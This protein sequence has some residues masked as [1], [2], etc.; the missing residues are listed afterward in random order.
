MARH[1]RLEVL[2]VYCTLQGAE[3]GFDREFGI[4]VAWDVP[5]LDRYP[6]VLAPPKVVKP[7]LGSFWGLVNPGLWKL[8]R[9]GKFDA[10]FVFGHQYLSCW[11][12]ILATKLSRSALIMSCD[13]TTLT[14]QDGGDWKVPLK[15]FL[16]P[17]IFGLAEAVCAGSSGTVNLLESLAVAKQR[18]ILSPGTTDNSYF[19]RTAR[20]ASRPELRRSW[21]LPLE[22]PVVLFCGKLQSWKRPQDLLEA[23]ARSGV[24][25]AYLIY[26]GE[27][28]MRSQLEAMAE[29]LRVGERVRF[30]GFLNQSKIPGA[31][32]ASDVLVLPSEYETFG[33]VVSEAM[34]CGLPTIVSDGVGARFDLID[35]HGTGVV[36]PS[37]NVDALASILRE[38]LPDGE[39]LHRMGETARVRMQTW[40]PK[41]KMESLLRAIE[42]AVEERQGSARP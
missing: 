31:Y 17:R 15:K 7:R 3:P 11:I 10:V 19:E 27:G 6:W 22:A 8:I 25:G 39:R 35:G 24:P 38:F 18:I 30:L 9:N 12:A 23:F 34:A 16:L 21:N 13:A 41:E 42:T 32:V 20:E 26:V 29:Q 28:P 36:Y 14:P 2:V 37:G 1:P 40:S 4:E 5:Q 33:M